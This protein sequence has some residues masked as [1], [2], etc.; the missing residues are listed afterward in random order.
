MPRSKSI[1]ITIVGIGVICMV[2]ASI[3]AFRFYFPSY[4]A[5]AREAAENYLKDT[6]AEEMEYEAIRL[7]LIDPGL[8][9]VLFHVKS[10]PSIKFIVLIRPE[11]LSLAH[12]PDNYLSQSFSYQIEQEYGALV[13]KL[14]GTEAEIKV[15]AERSVASFQNTDSLDENTPKEVL[16]RQLDYTIYITTGEKYP[17]ADLKGEVRRISTLLN[18]LAND[19]ICANAVKA[20]YYEDETEREKYISLPGVNSF[21]EQMI[22]ECLSQ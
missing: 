19:Q 20:V 21:S 5:K 18:A 17:L 11:D 15:A 22:E 16:S 8:Y 7:P 3:Y 1:I 14:W 2:V 4:K 12:Y 6:Y 10:N 9:N 13:R